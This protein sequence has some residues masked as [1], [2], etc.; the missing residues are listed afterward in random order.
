M[1]KRI[2]NRKIL[3]PV[4]FLWFGL[5]NAFSHFA[6][7]DSG[8]VPQTEKAGYVKPFKLF[9]N[10]YYVGDKWVS[11]YLLLTSE[12]LV[13]VDTLEYPW[14]QW[15]ASNINELGFDTKDVNLILIT[16][17]HSDHASGAGWL[18]VQS[19]AEIAMT[20]ASHQQ[21]NHWLQKTDNASVQSPINV[22][23]LQDNEVIKRGDTTLNVISTPG[24]T[25]GAISIALDVFDNNTPYRALIFGGVGT[26]FQS[27]TL[28]KSYQESVLKLRRLHQQRPF[29]VNLANHPH[30]AQLFE[31]KLNKSGTNP[32]I[33]R[34]GFGEFLE[35][36]ENMGKLKFRELNQK[37]KTGAA[38]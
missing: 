19:G 31:R 12:G 10:L 5:L 26:N 35:Q 36:I 29:D 22:E 16:H 8:P 15:I 4:L 2:F 17:G 24:H 37:V 23:Y 25:E 14:S 18:Q 33:D 34:K 32:Y 28:A 38:P 27:L 3:P 30:R 13:L 21:L 7:A 9:D 6:M 1:K 20:A 11:S